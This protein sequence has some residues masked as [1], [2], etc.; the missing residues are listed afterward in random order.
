MHSHIKSPSCSLWGS[1]AQG[2]GAGKFHPSLVLN[3]ALPPA[4]GFVGWHSQCTAVK[5]ALSSSSR[6]SQGTEE[7]LSE[8]KVCLAPSV[9]SSSSR[10]WEPGKSLWLGHQCIVPLSTDLRAEIPEAVPFLLIVPHEL[11]FHEFIV[12]IFSSQVNF[13]PARQNSPI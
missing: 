5:T 12:M 9:V 11:S 3:L 10:E 13:W 4:A 1:D 7:V 8:G 6:H 2:D